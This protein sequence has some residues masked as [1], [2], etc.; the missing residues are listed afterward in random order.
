[1]EYNFD[2]AV[3]SKNVIEWTR[4]WMN[5]KGPDSI[6]VLG[7]SGGIDSTLTGKF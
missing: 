3:E 2:V 6:A 7:I 1:M 5:E 4:N